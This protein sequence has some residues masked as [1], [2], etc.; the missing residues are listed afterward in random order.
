MYL[1]HTLNRSDSELIQR[2]FS[3][4]RESPTPGD[5]VELVKEDLNNIGEAFDEE[6]ICMRSKD[7]FKKII[8]ENIRLS[9]FRDLKNLQMKH[10]K[11]YE[12]SI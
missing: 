9:A 11:N 12:H 6:T 7:Q 8:K 2:V 1:H 3:A 4:Q 10:S 5:F